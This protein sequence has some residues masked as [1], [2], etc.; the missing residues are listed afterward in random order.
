MPIQERARGDDGGDLLE[1]MPTDFLGLSGQ[2]SALVVVEPGLFA[3]SLL[4]DF[5][6]LLEI[7]DDV[8]LVAVEPAGQTDE[9]EL[10]FLL[11]FRLL[12]TTNDLMKQPDSREIPSQTR[13]IGQYGVDRLGVLAP[14]E[15]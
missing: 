7:L 13:I 8:L 6:L 15:P 1:P 5:D 3:Q 12:R 14:R 2:S 11:V 9:D 10:I 4:E